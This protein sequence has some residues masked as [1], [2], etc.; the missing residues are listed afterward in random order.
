MT[1]DIKGGLKNTDI[2]TNKYVVF[3]ELLS[4]AIDSYLIRRE[5]EGF[6]DELKVE[7]DINFVQD[8]LF[9]EFGKNSIEITCTDNGAG[10]G[11]DQIKAFITRDSTFKDY[12]KI[13]GLGKCKG[14]GRI[15]FF[16]FFQHLNVKSVI[17]EN[18]ELY[19]VEL[20]VDENT[21]EIHFED[22]KKTLVSN[23]A[24]ETSITLAAPSTSA[25]KKHFDEKSM[26]IDFSPAAIKQHLFLTFLNRL[27]FLKGVIGDFEIN[28]ISSS[29]DT[30]RPEKICAIE[31]PS[32]TEERVI[33]L[34]CAHGVAVGKNKKL[35]V[36]RY[37]LPSETF[38][39]LQHEVALCANSAIVLSLAKLYLKSQRD[40][41]KPLEN[42][43]ELIFVESELLEST[44]N[45]QRDNFSLP[46][47]CSS[48]YT[49][50]N[51][52]SIQDIVD[53]IEDYVYQI[54]TPKDF[55][56]D[57]LVK[58]TSMRFGITQAMISEANI[59][60]RYSDN[61][62]NIAKRVLKKY[63][64]DI[65]NDTSDIFDLKSELL[66]LDP[67]NESF[68]EKIGELSWKYTSTIKKMDMANLSQLV[69]RRS[70]IL[71]ILRMSVNSTLACQQDKGARQEN[72]KI[73]HNIFF[74]T[75]K[76]SNDSV[77]HDIW[78]LNEEHHYFDH[79]SSDK[80]LASIPWSEEK[81]VFEEDIDKHLEEIFAQNNE[82]H[83]LKRPDIAI[84]NEE[85]AAI[86]VEF[87]APG[88]ALQDHTNDLIQY[89]RL[90]CA[91]SHGKIRKIYGYLI[92]DTIDDSR[93]PG[94]YTPFPSGTGYFNSEPI[95]DHKT[96]LAYGEL[97][98]E[99]LLYEQFVD[100]AEK[101]LEKYRERLNLK[102]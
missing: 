79:I 50:N 73:I 16:H 64:D 45:E 72:E 88:V 6:N 48:N 90:L 83:R 26:H 66:K 71:D 38:R 28:I 22:F 86:I 31:L 5:L 62:E 56:K 57:E 101:R 25:F 74:P 59:K 29:S 19:R 34:I 92:G 53:S 87:K 65:V 102:S 49:L 14:T 10:F 91:K 67:R 1:L 93:M 35:K 78:L 15:Q 58:S 47:D 95:R 77:D 96:Q 51:E 27:L 99:I 7:I 32:P 42:N 39:A 63:Q 85:G 43:Y 55:D 12:L 98:S 11:E 52:F 97:Y 20:H 41:A 17:E 37:S 4:N 13:P 2:S 60:I 69:V 70:S 18:S 89:A 40:R 3:D 54:L 80:S 9:E 76:D 30:L 82:I 44:V 81:K 68:R 21:R 84:F 94:S 75:G 100:R 36:T 8:T 61:E 23:S 46:K 24:K 33:P